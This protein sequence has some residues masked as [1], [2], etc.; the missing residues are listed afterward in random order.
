MIDLFNIPNSQQDIQIF[1]ANGSAWQTWQK[2]RKCNYVYIMCIGG[3]GGG[4]GG[5]GFQNYVLTTGGGS[6]AVSRVLYNS[7]QLPDRLYIQVGL[8]GNGG[9]AGGVSSVGLGGSSG[10]RSTVS[11]QPVVA[12][13][14][15]VAISGNAAATG[16]NAVP[17]SVGETVSTQST[18]T[19]YTLSNFISTAG[20]GTSANG[21]LSQANDITP[22]TSQITCP[23]GGGSSANLNSASI[24][25]TSISPLIPSGTLNPSGNGGNGGNGIMS[26]KPFYSLGG[27][28]GGSSQS[29]GIGGNGGDG[30]IGSGGG[31]GGSGAGGGGTGGKGGDGLV[32]IISF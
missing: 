2:P 5:S 23:G 32:I 9:I 13:Q 3:A 14:N 4:G 20:V 28:G 26:W 11:L 21:S 19:F 7:Q 16:G 18:A 12:S 24:L 17:G 22:L 27:A 30:G 29:G 15:L 10:T 8:G 25:A 31:G 6:G 1:N